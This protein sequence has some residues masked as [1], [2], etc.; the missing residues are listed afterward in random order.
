MHS[1]KTTLNHDIL[2]ILLLNAKSFT[3]REP[4]GIRDT[5]NIICTHWP[6]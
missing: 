4:E 6:P 1:M 3:E 2:N 5:F